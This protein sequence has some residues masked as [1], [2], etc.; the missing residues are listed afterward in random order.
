MNMGNVARSD[1]DGTATQPP[2]SETRLKVEASSSLGEILDGLRDLEEDIVTISEAIGN[3]DADD[4][5]RHEGSVLRLAYRLGELRVRLAGLHGES[6][7]KAA[8]TP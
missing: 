6:S 5:P 2:A 4:R 3:P 8:G 1:R 7:A